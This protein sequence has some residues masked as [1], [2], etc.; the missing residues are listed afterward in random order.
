MSV[1]TSDNAA[2]IHPE[3]LAA[4]ARVNQD[5]A[6]AYGDDAYTARALACLRAQFGD[7]AEALL[8]WGGTAANVIG[9]RCVTEPYEAVLCAETAHLA[10]DECAAPERFLGGKLITLPVVHGKITPDAVRRAIHGVGVVHAAQPRVLSIA[11]PS[12]VGTVYTLAELGALADVCRERGLLL[13]VDG[14]RL[15]NA[16]AHL[17]LPLRAL[18]TEVGVDLLSFGG[19]KSGLMGAEAIVLLR[20]EHARGARFHRKQGMQLAS[21]MRF[22]AAQLEALLTDD[23][24]LRIARHAN[25][26]ARR[27]A[28]GVRELP[29]VELAHPVETNAVFARLP[30]SAVAALHAAGYQFLVWA[31]DPA[32]P[33]VRWMTAFDTTEDDVDRFIAAITATPAT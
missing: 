10:V 11:Q 4:I 18:T 27:L 28:A 15:P 17:E 26:A 22:L 3:V 21:K 5:R 23:L 2:G 31:P 14:A 7:Q 30:T 12:E 20:P 33:L 16:A 9:L 29:H 13:H 25:A 1:F 8:V 19:T 24:W 6:V 32:R